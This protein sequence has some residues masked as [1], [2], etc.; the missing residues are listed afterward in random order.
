LEWKVGANFA[1]DRTVVTNCG[2][3]EWNKLGKTD[4]AGFTGASVSGTESLGVTA[5]VNGSAPNVFYG[6]LT[7]GLVGEEHVDMTPPFKG[8]RLE[9]GDPK[10][11][12]TN[13]NGQVEESDKVII[14]NPNPDFIFAITNSLRVGKFSFNVLL[15]EWL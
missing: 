13:G 8:Q 10:F 7:Q 1:I 5:F 12:D 14:G 6:Y 11:I 3:P 9:V 15:M 4:R 2:L